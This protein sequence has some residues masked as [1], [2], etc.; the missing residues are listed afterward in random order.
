MEN[1]E[2]PASRNSL[3]RYDRHHNRRRILD[4]FVVYISTSS[5]L[6]FSESLLAGDLVGASH[7]SFI[8]AAQ[9][10]RPVLYF[11]IDNTLYPKSG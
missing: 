10:A 5:K 6:L 4:A 8:M 2:R 3:G 11:D 7:T 9:D 1:N